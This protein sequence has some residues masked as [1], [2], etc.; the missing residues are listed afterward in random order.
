MSE[1]F[2]VT[3]MSNTLNLKAGETYEGYILISNP[4]NSEGDFDYLVEVAPYGVTNNNYDADLTTA[5]GRT[6]LAEWVKIS[7]A[8][9]IIK[10]NEKVRVEYTITVPEDAAGGGQYA[11]L[12]VSKNTHGEVVNANI[13]VSN[14][15]GMASILYATI[16]GEIDRSSEVL[17]NSIP[18]FTT[19]LPVVSSIMLKNDGNIHEEA[20]I[21]ISIKNVLNGE[22]V[23]PKEGST[24][25][26]QEEILPGTTRYLTESIQDI[27]PLGIYEVTQTVQYLDQDHITTQILIAC[28]IWFMFLAFVTVCSILSFIV[29]RIIKHKKSKE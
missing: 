25:G 18:G 7:N 3:P 13:G 26:I 23:Y 28:P 17:E 12:V 9:G 27:S 2:T 1:K 22:K 24:G 8:T 20:N 21:Y 6:L 4:E 11:A 15:F 29:S 19:N 14:V 10:P 5:S 16:D